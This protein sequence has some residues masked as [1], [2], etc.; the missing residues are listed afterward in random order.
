MGSWGTSGLVTDDSKTFIFDNLK[1]VVIEGACGVPDRG[2]ISK[3]G[4]NN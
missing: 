2:D 3:I 1:S 4:K